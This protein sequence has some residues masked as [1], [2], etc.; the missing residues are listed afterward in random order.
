MHYGIDP[1][2]KVFFFVGRVDKEKR[3]DVLLQ[4]FKHLERDDV[5]LV[6]GGKGAALGQMEA[7][8]RKLGLGPKV[9][10]TG[11]IPN[12]D[13]PGVLN[14]IDVF[15]MPSE[16]ELL[17]ISSLEAMACK[18]PMLV[19]RAVALPELVDEGV[20]GLMFRP[21]DVADAVRC[22]TWFA[23]Q[24]GRW[25]AMGANSLKKVQPH[26]LGNMVSRYEELYA[27]LLSGTPLDG[28][29]A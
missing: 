23:D 7:L 28:L 15:V 17:S 5:Q 16:A 9:H 27:A 6:I 2:R 8:A 10:F 18:R 3:L 11:F 4:A 13:L 14:S 25:K 20:N 19:A 24:S 21:G 22:L 26:N 1:Q 29:Q 12:E